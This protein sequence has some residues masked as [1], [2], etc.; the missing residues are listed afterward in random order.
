MFSKITMFFFFRALLLG[1]TVVLGALATFIVTLSVSFASYCIAT[2]AIGFTYAP[3][4]SLFVVLY[5]GVFQ[6][7]QI[8][9]VLSI[10]GLLRMVFTLPAMYGI[11]KFH[12]GRRLFRL[13]SDNLQI[14]CRT[15]NRRN[16]WCE[17]CI[18]FMWNFHVCLCY[19]FIWYLSVEKRILY[20]IL[21]SRNSC[22]CS[23]FCKFASIVLLC[24]C[25]ADT[26]QTK[27]FRE[28]ALN[29]LSWLH[30]L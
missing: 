20:L 5:S 27:I 28:V 29:Y 30:E 3:Y 22:S 14:F 15:A 10:D 12:S 2:V 6:T 26:V 13:L 17:D 19:D 11:G 7:D 1:A 8:P 18:L 21:H 16:R 25:C 9:N 24:V 23:R 4:R